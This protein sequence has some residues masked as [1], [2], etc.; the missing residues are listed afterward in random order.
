M[1]GNSNISSPDRDSSFS[2]G[3]LLKLRGEDIA[4]FVEMEVNELIVVT[5]HVTRVST[6][7]TMAPIYLCY[8]FTSGKYVYVGDEDV[9]SVK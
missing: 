2:V 3:D 4:F 1:N 6:E 7:E 8:S 5:E 9:V